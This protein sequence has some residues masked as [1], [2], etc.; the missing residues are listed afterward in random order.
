MKSRDTTARTMLAYEAAWFAGFFDGEGSIFSYKGGSNGKS[1]CWRFSIA[2]TNLGSLEQC[3]EYAGCGTIGI[4]SAP[5]DIKHKQQWIYKINTKS[6]IA[7]VTEQ[8]LPYLCIKQ[9]AVKKFLEDY[10]V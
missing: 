9:E 2:N 6:N 5:Q 7:L 4:K 1:K 3:K 10:G 8:L